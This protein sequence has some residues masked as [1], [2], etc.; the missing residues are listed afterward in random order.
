M[1]DGI[2]DMSLSD[3]EK[4]H[5][6]EVLDCCDHALQAKPSLAL[7]FDATCRASLRE[8]LLSAS[9]RSDVSY[10]GAYVAPYGE[11]LSTV[12]FPQGYQDR[13]ENGARVLLP[14]MS[15]GDR[16]Q[17]IERLR[18]SACC[19]GEEELLLA[20]GF[21]VEFGEDAIVAN[22]GESAERRPEFLV[23]HDGLSVAVEAKGLM[24]SYQIRVSN[25]YAIRS[26]QVSW[27]TFAGPNR[28]LSRL[29]SAVLKK[30]RAR[31]SSH[32]MVLCL[33]QYTAW[34]PAPDGAGTLA[35]IARD[36]A[37]FN[38]SQELLPLGLVYVCRR[39]LQGIWF[40]QHA[41]QMHEIS[42]GCTRRI[43]SAL[44]GAFFPRADGRLLSD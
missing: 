25:K 23:V 1:M 18:G 26:G 15:C 31:Q 14:R 32:P 37:E 5:V 16:Q 6:I 17:L 21:A 41:R 20:H 40:N 43:R 28:D 12:D 22:K 33:T 42:E 38:V 34:P 13:L 8:R 11:T 39:I 24:D 19:S 35:E 2:G 27:F 4:R 3:D 30:I 10:P 44:Q 9:S 29:R 7:I 36:P